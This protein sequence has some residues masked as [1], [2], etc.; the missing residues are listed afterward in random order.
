LQ[1]DSG[2]L[3]SA[4]QISHL[5]PLLLT[6]VQSEAG[7]LVQ[8]LFPDP[9]DDPAIAQAALQGLLGAENA[10]TLSDIPEYDLAN[11]TSMDKLKLPGVDEIRSTLVRV[12]TDGVWRCPSRDFAERRTKAGGRDVWVGEWSKGKK[13]PSNEGGSICQS[14]VVCHEVSRARLHTGGRKD[15][16]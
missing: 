15:M 1:T 12:L 4:D 9:I 7:A 2:G 14:V 3:T 10:Q 6:T 11:R 8:S 5:V 13:Y 16:G